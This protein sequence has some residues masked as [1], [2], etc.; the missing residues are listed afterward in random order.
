MECERRRVCPAAT[1]LSPPEL[2]HPQRSQC[3]QALDR[4]SARAQ[5]SGRMR[6]AATRGWRSDTATRRREQSSCG[7]GRCAAGRLRVRAMPYCAPGA[8]SGGERDRVVSRSWALEVARWTTQLPK[9][10]LQ[11]GCGACVAR[12]TSPCR[13]SV[14]SPA[15]S[16]RPLRTRPAIRCATWS[17]ASSTSARFNRSSVRAF[18]ITIATF[19]H[20]AS[21]APVINASIALGLLPDGPVLVIVH[22]HC[23]FPGH[24]H[25]MRAPGLRR[26]TP[27]L[28]APPHP[29]PPS[30]RATYS[31]PSGAT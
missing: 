19:C 6:C 26:P 10:M 18:A 14:I 1:G 9:R 13:Q 30:P 3:T 8:L 23:L 11:R 17:A 16:S 2:P 27:G 28:A 25:R 29:Q 15:A 5:R 20:C 22:H 24:G 4:R 21:T 31:S 7:C 12:R